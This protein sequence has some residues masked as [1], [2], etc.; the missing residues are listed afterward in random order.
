MTTL[1]T[2]RPVG[3][4]GLWHLG[5]TIAASWA[6]LGTTVRAIDFDDARIAGLAGGHPPVYEPGL[7]EALGQAAGAGVLEFSTDPSRLRGSPTTIFPTAFSSTID[8]NFERKSGIACA[9]P[10]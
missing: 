9:S 3:V 1:S 4:V 7:A 8:L 10:L 6:G 5:C 2:S